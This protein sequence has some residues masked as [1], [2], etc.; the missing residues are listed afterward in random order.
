MTKT[1]HPL[2]VTSLNPQV[3]YLHPLE[4]QQLVHWEDAALHAMVDFKHVKAETIGPDEPID[5]ALVAI[6]NCSFHVLLVVNAEQMILGLVSAEDLLGE[7]PLKAIEHRRLARADISVH[8]VMIPQ[9]EILTLDLESLRHAKVGHVVQTLRANKQHYALVVKTDED[10]GT[11]SVRG[12]FS[13][14]LISK[15]LGKDVMS[16][17]SEAQSIAELQ[18][19]LHLND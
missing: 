8:M 14:P 18:H 6:K 13:S 15:Q 7:K 9:R 12:L 4:P 10:T 5:K 17:L 16:D 1:Y 2:S 11:Q 3:T 19:N